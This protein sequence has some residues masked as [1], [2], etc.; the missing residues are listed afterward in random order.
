MHNVTPLSAGHLNGQTLKIELVESG[1]DLPNT[2]AIRWPDKPTLCPPSQLRCHGG[3]RDA[4]PGE[5]G[6]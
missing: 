5:L 6:R 3:C 2:V 1:N 4:D